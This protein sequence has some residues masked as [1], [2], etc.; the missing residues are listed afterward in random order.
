VKRL[1]LLLA[2]AS[3]AHA[4]PPESFWRALHVVET[5]SRQGPILGDNGRS[6]GPLQ[7]SRAYFTDSR[8]AGTYEQVV[9]LPFARRVVSAYLQ[10]YAPA[11]WAAG[12]VETLARIHNGGPRGDRKQATINYAAKVRRA[13]R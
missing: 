3:A 13:M 9:D 4:A 11:A 12:D 6:L 1:A 8:V 2:L 10:R 5:S 7:I